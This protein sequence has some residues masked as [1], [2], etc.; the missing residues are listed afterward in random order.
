[1]EQ[2][3]VCS[4]K[5]LENNMDGQLQLP[6]SYA[7]QVQAIKRPSPNPEIDQE[8]SQIYAQQAAQRKAYLQAQA[9]AIEQEKA[10]RLAAFDDDINKNLDPTLFNYPQVQHELARERALIE[11]D[12][13]RKSGLMKTSGMRSGQ[14]ER[15]MH[16]LEKSIENRYG[17]ILKPFEETE[18]HKGAEKNWQQLRGKHD[19]LSNLNKLIEEAQ[20]I[21]QKSVAAEQAGDSELAASLRKRATDFSSQS[22]AK[23]LNSAITSSDAISV[24]EMLTKFPQLLTAGQQAQLQKVGPFSPN[25]L[26]A[27]WMDMDRGEK[28]GLINDFVKVF[29]SDPGSFL[30]NAT[31]AANIFSKNYNQSLKEQVIDVTSPGGAKRMGAVPIKEIINLAPAEAKRKI[32]PLDTPRP[33]GQ[34]ISTGAATS[35]GG[36]APEQEQ[37]VL[38]RPLGG[39]SSTIFTINPP[40]R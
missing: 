38:N 11:I 2:N 39:V 17:S 36:I 35:S 6:Q 3:Q 26:V 37:N 14:G 29:Q 19:I 4:I 33:G 34:Q 30:V 1:V 20:G 24:G 10:Q 15:E 40:R 28:K 22:I 21:Y 13:L 16:A 23:A 9:A 7:G 31:D 5:G 27:R 12:A 32:N 25:M 18:G 8:I